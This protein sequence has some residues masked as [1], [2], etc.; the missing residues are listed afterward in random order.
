MSIERPRGCCGHWLI[1]RFSVVATPEIGDG[2]QGL[3]RLV[4]GL[5]AGETQALYLALR[6]RQETAMNALRPFIRQSDY[7]EA[8][9]ELGEYP[10][11]PN[12]YR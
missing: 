7:I 10:C 3:D 4:S 8:L 2:G 1:E 5:G 12:Q 11:Q 9:G 6:L